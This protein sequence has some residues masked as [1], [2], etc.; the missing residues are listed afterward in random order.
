M[1]IN[2]VDYQKILIALS[3][4][5]LFISCKSINQSVNQS[6]SQSINQ[7]EDFIEFWKNTLLE[8]DETSF[9][10]R[11]IKKDSVDNKYIF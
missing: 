1:K 8:L 6:V 3:F 9:D 4:T 7:S 11:I 5:F 10:V 2:L